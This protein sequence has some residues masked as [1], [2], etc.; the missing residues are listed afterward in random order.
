MSFG[1]FLENELLDHVFG[2]AGA[3]YVSPASIYIGL[4]TSDGGE[5][6]TECGEPWGL[7]TYER[8]VMT[9][10]DFSVAADGTVTND[11]IE[12]FV[13]AGAAWGSITDFML[14]DAAT[15]GNFL[16]G[17]QLAAMKYIDSGD[18]ARFAV[19]DMDIT[20]A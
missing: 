5:A 6:G 3:D 13:E 10:G 14:F 9:P 8:V 1:N 16:G 15:V 20:L 4:G 7:G 18:T 11:N 19:N 2:M 12:T 17:G